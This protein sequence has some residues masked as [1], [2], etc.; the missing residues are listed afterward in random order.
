VN[1]KPNEN[2]QVVV[3]PHNRYG[4]AKAGDLIWVT[5][6]EL[7]THPHCLMLV[8]EPTPPAARTAQVALPAEV[9]KKYG[10]PLGR[11][12]EGPIAFEVTRLPSKGEF[13]RRADLERAAA[14]ARAGRSMIDGSMID[15]LR[16]DRD[17]IAANFEELSYDLAQRQAAGRSAALDQ[18]E[19]VI[20]KLR[21]ALQVAQDNEAA[22]R[23]DATRLAQEN[24]QFKADMEQA[25]AKPAEPQRPQPAP[26]RRG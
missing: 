4:E 16:A 2:V 26:G 8:P 6:H 20:E 7:A 23:A 13:P 19:A 5:R 25:R 1:V 24:A 21:Q 14:T 15:A 22:A 18:A 11:R 12:Q 9:A 3:K 10:L 17:H